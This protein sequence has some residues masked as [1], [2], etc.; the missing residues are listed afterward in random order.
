M[1]DRGTISD[2]EVLATLSG[3]QY[4]ESHM[5][6]YVDVLKSDIYSHL[7]SKVPQ[8]IKN[9]DPSPSFI[10]STIGTI[11]VFKVKRSSTM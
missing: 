5:T 4:Q 9:P 1:I 6:F 7:L 8:D 3:F 10:W 2:T 11:T